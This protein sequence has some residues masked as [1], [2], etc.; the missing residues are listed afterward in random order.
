MIYTAVVRCVP[1]Q[2]CWSSGCVVAA[3]LCHFKMFSGS[4]ERQCG[5]AF[6]AGINQMRDCLASTSLT[7]NE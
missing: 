6:N 3:L 4:P 5:A 7:K 2:S 1:A